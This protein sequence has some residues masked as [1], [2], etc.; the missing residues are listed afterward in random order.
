MIRPGGMGLRARLIA[1]LLATLIPLVGLGG[2]WILSEF[3]EERARMGHEVQETAERV[4]AQVG[5]SVA[6]VQER[7]AVLAR[8]P[9]VQIESNL[10]PLYADPVR[11]KQILFNLLSNAVKFTPEHDT[12]MV[13]ARQVPGCESRGAEEQ[14]SKGAGEPSP[15]PPGP[16][17]ATREGHRWEG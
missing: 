15:L 9:A 11:L 1:L 13:M 3:R 5:H 7:L 10:P 14:G 16:G 6:G 4:A 12:I 17:P 8:L 2:Y